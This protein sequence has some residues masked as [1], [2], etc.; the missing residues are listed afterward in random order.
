[1]NKERRRAVRKIM[2]NIA[3]IEQEL[4]I[5]YSHEQ[6]AFE[7]L[8]EGFQCSERGEESEEAIDLMDE[9]LDL[10]REAKDKLDEIT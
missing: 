5:V 3:E 7:N 10:L 9:A 4:K 2:K 1:M 6:M 8:P